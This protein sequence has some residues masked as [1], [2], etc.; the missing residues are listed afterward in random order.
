MVNKW[1]WFR[2]GFG[3]AII[4][5]SIIAVIG[6][7]GFGAISMNN[8]SES[9]T[10]SYYDYSAAPM[11]SAG[12]SIAL[13]DGYFSNSEVPATGQVGQQIAE[14]DRLIIKDASL[15]MTVEDTVETIAAINALISDVD[16]WMVSSSTSTYM[17]IEDHTYQS[18]L[19]QVRVPAE[20]FD[21]IL[22]QMKALAET[23]NGETVNG[24]DVTAEYV[25]LTSQ[26]ENLEAAEEQLQLIMD[27][28]R[29][30]EDVLAVYNQLVDTRGEI[31][32]TKG[33]MEYLSQSAVYSSITLTLLPVVPEITTITTTEG[34]D[35]LH[36]VED[37]AE[38]LVTG[39]QYIINGLIWLLI[40]GLPFTLLIMGIAYLGYRISKRM[41]FSKV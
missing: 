15:N 39:G 41:S 2:R 12:S 14:Q 8:D 18:A 26:L 36:T 17:T 9:A 1:A 40:V 20:Q 16:G 37:A 19:L 10:A 13:T 31:N 35:P 32:V 24:Q 27:N 7:L 34:W 11:D 21:L 28:A 33:R 30:T 6:A 4:L 29:T 38:A 3:A 22:S 5:V 25:D 23:V